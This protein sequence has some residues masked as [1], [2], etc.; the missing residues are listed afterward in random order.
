MG[1][2]LNQASVD[3]RLHWTLDRLLA[4]GAQV[5][6][7]F[8]PEHGLRGEAQAGA[9]VGHA[10]HPRLGVPI[11]SLYGED[12]K[13]RAEMLAGI[14]L[15]L[16]DLPDGGSRYWTFLYTMA[17]ALEAC[18]QAGIPFL[19]LDRPNP[20]GGLQVEGNLVTEAFRSFVGGY[21]LPIRHGMT[22]GEI[23]RWLAGRHGIGG[24]V[25]EVV[26]AQGWTR[27]QYFQDTG[28]LW[29]SPSP[30]IPS[31][32]TLILYPGTCLVEGTNCSEG[33][34]TTHPFQWIG[35]PWIDADALAADLNRRA[36]PGSYFR[37]VYFTPT[38][39]KHAHE[40]CA[41][42][43]VHVLDNRVFQPV[44]VGLHLL[45]ALRAQNPERFAWIESDGR[46]FIDLLAGTDQLRRSLEQGVFPEEIWRGWEQELQS[47]LPERQQFLL[48]PE[49]R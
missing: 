4:A 47:F 11:Y 38:F 5:V 27:D 41:G 33:R 18:G 10:R 46:Y 42:V 28:L 20:I 2:L 3:S 30:N 36:L 23:A 32:E 37:P 39:S 43:E 7:L 21:P 31:P 22:M 12:R 26:P 8:G 15:F 25:L 40:L 48:Y 17:Y 6:A 1:L 16:C 45:A 49:S 29:A 9:H 13:P 35:A 14:D 24:G 44:R 34:G 19:L